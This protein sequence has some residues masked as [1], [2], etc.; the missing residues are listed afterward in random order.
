MLAVLVCAL[1]GLAAAANYRPLMHYLDAK[2][3]LEQRSAEVAS[4]EA[5]NA[6]LQSQLSKLLQ[7][8][9]LEQL[10]RKDLTYALP[11]ED[12]YI[13]TGGSGHTESVTQHT[14][15]GAGGQLAPPVAADGSETASSAGAPSKAST[16]APGFFERLLARIA[17]LF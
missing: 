8:G 17:D 15:E 16:G 14:T 2:A 4:Q 3:R 12:L 6:E 11:G 1:L 13:V 7:P 9:Y 5:R 10:A